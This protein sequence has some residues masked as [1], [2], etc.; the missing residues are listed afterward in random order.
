MI[1]LNHDWVIVF[2]SFATPKVREVQHP[3]S[4]AAF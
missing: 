3:R 2:L 4:S 1:Y